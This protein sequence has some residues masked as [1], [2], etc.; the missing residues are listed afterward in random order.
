MASV[1]A[2]SGST[3]VLEGRRALVSDN[4]ASFG[5]S[6]SHLNSVVL[7]YNRAFL[8]MSRLRTVGPLECEETARPVA[9]AE[10]YILPVGKYQFSWLYCSLRE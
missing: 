5:K 3:R 7:A 4:Q 9:K 1:N 2:S 10:K 8:Q 6:H